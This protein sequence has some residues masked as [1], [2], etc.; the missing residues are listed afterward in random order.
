MVLRI[1]EKKSDKCELCGGKLVYATDPKE[2]RNLN[3]DFCEKMF[4][5]N[6]YCENGHYICDNCHSKNPIEIIERICEET[7]IK[8]PFKLA[9]LIMKHHNFKVYGP[10]HHVLTPAVILTSLRNNGIKKVNGD[11]ITLFDIKEGIKYQED[12]VDSMVLVVQV[13]DLE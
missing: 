1:I 6:I 11:D 7:N 9:D 8:D 3:C 12:G 13:W 5:T 2:Q 10:E 4:T